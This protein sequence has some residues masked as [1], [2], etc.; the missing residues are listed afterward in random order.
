MRQ[1]AAAD[2]TD[3]AS[4]VATSAPLGPD[5]L[6]TR[7]FFLGGLAVGVLA[8]SAAGFAAATLV[9]S[10]R[11]VA[12][13]S[14]APAPTMLT[15]VARWHVP[16]ETIAVTG[17]V[18]PARTI[19]V[20]ASAPFRVI[21]VTRMPVVAGDR[22]WPGHVIAEVDGRPIVLLRGRLPAY[23]DLHEG[24]SGPDVAQLHEALD[25][26]GYA[27]YDPPG[28]FGPSTAFALLLLYQHLGYRAPLYHPREAGR[29][30]SPADGP[31]IPG[32]YLPMSEVTYIPGRSALVVSVRAQVGTVVTD[33]PILRLATGHPHVTAALSAYQVALVRRSMRVRIFAASLR[34]TITGVLARVGQIPTAA[35]SAPS[36]ATGTGGTAT[37]QYPIEV[38]S[39]RPL[40]QRLVGTTVWLTTSA[41]VT[42]RPVLSVP[43]AGIFGPV[44]HR[45]AY[46]IKIAGR[47]RT[48]VTVF[49]GPTADGLVAVQSVRRGALRP[50]DRVLIGIGAHL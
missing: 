40:P 4:L 41:P 13:R 7:R 26:A 10:P 27:D 18:A 36:G 35:K 19:N 38:T 34:L 17:V 29:S 14:A 32:A 12:S 31:P 42:V 15:A 1:R 22:V 44:P 33:R 45:P 6:R 9:E 47:R 49:T 23:R 43:L 48:K 24:D 46:V 5:P 25:S 37:T 2:V 39:R 16:T 20:T 21:T 11:D 30:A 8:M 28:M 3:G 50:G